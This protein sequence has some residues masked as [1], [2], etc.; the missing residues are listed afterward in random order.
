[1]AASGKQRLS[2]NG[3]ERTF[4]VQKK[5]RAWR[6][7]LESCRDRLFER[8]LA[9]QILARQLAHGRIVFL[10]IFRRFPVSFL[11]KLFHERIV[12]LLVGRQV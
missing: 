10:R 12:T 11:A 7:F 5:P 4:R 9:H 8:D 1:M 2:A 3:Q 6:G